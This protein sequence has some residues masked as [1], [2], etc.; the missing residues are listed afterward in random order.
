[1]QDSLPECP[2]HSA[3]TRCDERFRFSLASLVKFNIC[4][5]ASGT[6]NWLAV[7]AEDETNQRSG[8]RKEA[9]DVRALAGEFRPVDIAKADIIRACVETQ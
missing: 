2:D 3:L 4:C 9:Q 6:S 7:H 1:L 5:R 8:S